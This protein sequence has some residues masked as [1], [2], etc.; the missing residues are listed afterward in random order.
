MELQEA[1]CYF[2]KSFYLL[3]HCINLQKPCLCGIC[4][5]ILLKISLADSIILVQSAGTLL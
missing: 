4:F 5:I 2:D 1:N 3:I